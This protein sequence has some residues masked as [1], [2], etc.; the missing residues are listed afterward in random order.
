MG[1]D[2]RG[3]WLAKET[4]VGTVHGMALHCGMEDVQDVSC[5]IL[6]VIQVCIC[7]MD[8]GC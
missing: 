4:N 1:C 6:W 3:G 7:T 8:C 5:T 2:G